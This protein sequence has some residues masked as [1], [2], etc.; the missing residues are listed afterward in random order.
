MV[1]FADLSNTSS[2][3]KVIRHV[4]PIYSGDEFR[5]ISAVTVTDK[6]RN[7]KFSNVFFCADYVPTGRTQGTSLCGWHMFRCMERALHIV[8][9]V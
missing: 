7:R 4:S 5:K 8:S 1:I 3:Y 6:C 2:M 9:L